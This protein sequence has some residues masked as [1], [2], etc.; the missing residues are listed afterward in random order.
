MLVPTYVYETIPADDGARPVVFEIQQR[1]AD[2][3]LTHHPETGEPVRRV[4]TAPF[5]GGVAHKSDAPVARDE[6]GAGG[7]GMGMCGMGGCGGGF[8]DA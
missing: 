2:A 5:L 6:P 7:C 1:M 3:A 8:G 4:L